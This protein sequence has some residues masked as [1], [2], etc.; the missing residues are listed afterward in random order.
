MK[1][2]GY[3]LAIS[4]TTFLSA[5]AFS[6]EGFVPKAGDGEALMNGIVMK[7]SPRVG[8]SGP[9][10]AEQTFPRGADVNP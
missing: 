6:Q 5:A 7:L 4:V 2:P 1:A 9:I 3:V 8:T 10:L